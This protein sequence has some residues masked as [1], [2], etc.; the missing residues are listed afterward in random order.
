MLQRKILRFNTHT[1]THLHKYT[2]TQQTHN[3]NL[4]SICN[5]FC[6]S[7]SVVPYHFGIPLPSQ[8]YGLVLFN[9]QTLPIDLSYGRNVVVW[10]DKRIQLNQ[11]TPKTR[12]ITIW[13]FHSSYTEQLHHKNKRN[14][15]KRFIFFAF[16]I[17]KHISKQLNFYDFFLLCSDTYYL[18]VY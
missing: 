2:D 13:Q 5:L 6:K 16:F 18:L 4:F 12:S 1:Y 10:A 11:W 17:Q 14:K 8:I 15:T 3:R 7:H 9:T